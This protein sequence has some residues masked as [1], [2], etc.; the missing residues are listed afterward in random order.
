MPT[1]TRLALALFVAV[2][3][4][5]TFYAYPS[6]SGFM[7][8]T[9]RAVAILG[10]IAV[11]AIFLSAATK[12]AP[13]RLD[14]ILVLASIGIVAAS[15]VQIS[16]RADA[17]RLDAE[18]AEAGESNVLDVLQTTETNTGALVRAG[19]ELRTDANA[20]ID[21]VIAG[22]WDD[23]RLVL[24]ASPDAIDDAQLAQLADR[25]ALLRDAEERSRGTIDDR[26]Q[27][28]IEAIPAIETPLPDSARLVYVDTALNRVE[29]DRAYF[30]QRLALA[31]NRLE[32]TAEL[33][34]FLRAN[35]DDFAFN[36]DTQQLAFEDPALADTY[37][38]YLAEIDATWTA[39]DALIAAH[40]N[41]EIAAV[42]AL[43][44]AAGTTP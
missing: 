12:R 10:A 20:E 23:E 8:L 27:S 36:N 21:L 32:T 29:D 37:A 15:W 6:W 30:H 13:R 19:N 35:L 31:A 40:R 7:T 25:V 43:V 42:L 9:V 34:D 16:A 14:I 38:A 2:I 17:A 18:I 39:E 44:E 33:I 11:T 5:L 41:G 24:T 26:L 1:T 3:L 22:L 28:E 4:A